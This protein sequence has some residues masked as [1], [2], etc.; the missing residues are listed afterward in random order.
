MAVRIGASR[1]HNHRQ[2]RIDERRI[3]REQTQ[4]ASL[5]NAGTG[6]AGDGLGWIV[7][8]AA[9]AVV[10]CSYHARHHPLP[11]I[12]LDLNLSAYYRLELR[13]FLRSAGYIRR[14]QL[15]AI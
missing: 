7:R 5:S 6:L 2:S 9:G 10:H 4:P 1:D 11:G 12:R 14:K 3:G 15:P 8:A 13:F